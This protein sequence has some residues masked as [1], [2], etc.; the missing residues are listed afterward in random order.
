MNLKEALLSVH[1][2][3]WLMEFAKT[4]GLKELNTPEETADV[5]S[6]TL[7]D[8]Q[9]M[10]ENMITLHDE[11]IDFIRYCLKQDQPFL[12]SSGYYDSADRLRDLQYGFVVDENMH[13]VMPD[14][15]KKAY[16]KIDT[17]AFH[18]KR[19]KM[20]WL[21]D[22]V[23]LIPYLYAILSV[24]D[25]GTLYRKHRGFEE[26]NEEIVMR[27]LPELSGRPHFP[28]ALE[29]N[30]LIT[31]GLKESGQEKRLRE[32]HE[33]I[34][35]SFPS[36]GEIKDLIQNGYPS[37]ETSWKKLRHTLIHDFR[38]SDTFIDA[39]LN[40]IWMYIATGNAFSDTLK[41]IRNESVPVRKE[42]EESL[43]A[44]MT[45]AWNHTR[46]IMCNGDTPEHAMPYTSYIF[47]D[48]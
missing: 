34:P 4:S 28:C 47:T 42:Q 14:D 1:D 24:G 15:V 36:Y 23:S 3:E 26:T 32:I 40:G 18:Q 39:L 27:M 48:N 31:K 8:P 43:K 29:G 19:K 37:K 6:E 13:F 21:N 38:V 5:I 7:L 41:M 44:V 22:C 45:E 9:I 33:T 20:A 10:M 11:D 25:L 35:V 12:P 30:E 16:Q 46:M 2:S 17:P